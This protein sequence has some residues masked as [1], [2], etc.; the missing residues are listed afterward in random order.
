MNDLIKNEV[1]EY[2]TPHQVHLLI[3]SNGKLI[4]VNESEYVFEVLVEGTEKPLEARVYKELVPN[5]DE[6]TIKAMLGDA[7][8]REY[9]VK[10]HSS[11]RLEQQKQ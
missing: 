3:M 5:V 1:G 7:I 9:T 2:L 4:E 10:Y 6:L 8:F 11:K